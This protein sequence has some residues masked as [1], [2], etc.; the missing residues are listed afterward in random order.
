MLRIFVLERDGK[1]IAISMNFV[2]GRSLR[3]S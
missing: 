1:A 2:E 3:A